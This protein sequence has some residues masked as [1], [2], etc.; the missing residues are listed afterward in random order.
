MNAK[1]QITLNK[2]MR[3]HEEEREDLFNYRQFWMNCYHFNRR[4]MDVNGAVNDANVA[5][6]AFKGLDTIKRKPKSNG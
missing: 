5:L 1:D 3:A 2:T 4:S 6:E